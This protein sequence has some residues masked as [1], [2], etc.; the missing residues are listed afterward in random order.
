MPDYKTMY[1]ELAG[2]VADTIDLLQ[3]ALQAG[4]IRYLLGADDR[5]EESGRLDASP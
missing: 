3:E 1:Y 4:E 5:A 2:Q